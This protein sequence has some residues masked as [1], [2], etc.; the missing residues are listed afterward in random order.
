M[1]GI[2]GF[3]NANSRAANREVLERMNRCIVHRG[4]DEDGFFVHESV[5]L[6]MRRLAIIDLAGGQQPIYNQDRSAVITT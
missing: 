6:A 5:A 2:V 4:P 1:C 3:V